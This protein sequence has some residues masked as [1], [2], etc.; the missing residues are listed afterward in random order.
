MLSFFVLIWSKGVARK[1]GKSGSFDHMRR[2]MN[3]KSFNPFSNLLISESLRIQRQCNDECC[4][5]LPVDK[6]KAD[7][8]GV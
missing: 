6:V 7:L 1:A 4:F 5:G 3:Q 8:I 2:G